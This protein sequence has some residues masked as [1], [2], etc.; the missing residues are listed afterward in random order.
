MKTALSTYSG[1]L[2]DKEI[3]R[4]CKPAEWPGEPLL[5]P[6]VDTQKGKPS[7][8]LGSFGYDLRLASTFLE[9][10][11]NKAA[12]LDPNAVEK[13]LFKKIV[14]SE[15]FVLAPHSQV[16]AETIEWFNMPPDL[17]AIILGKSSYARLG[18][19]VNATPAEPRWKGI[20]TLELANLSPLPIVLHVGQGIAQVLFFRGE[21]PARGYDEKE[22]GGGYMN[23]MGVTL[24]G[25]AAAHGLSR[26]A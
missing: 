10:E 11:A 15:V 22:S 21:E 4:L 7:Y 9:H 1:I 14:Q 2:N 16:L 8:G 5:H 6:F 26:K 24:S 20:L 23:Q 25:E 17:M 19:L 18:L 13:T 12:V 3:L